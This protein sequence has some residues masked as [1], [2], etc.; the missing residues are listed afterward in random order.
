MDTIMDVFGTC[1]YYVYCELGVSLG[2]DKRTMNSI[3]R[4]R[5]CSHWTRTIMSFKARGINWREPFW[6]KG[7]PIAKKYLKSW[8]TIIPAAL[9]PSFMARIARNTKLLVSGNN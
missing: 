4:D 2:Q 8:V 6:K 5:I 3:Y 7:F 9:V 1:M